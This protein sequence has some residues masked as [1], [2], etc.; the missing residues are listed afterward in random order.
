M[1]AMLKSKIHRVRINQVNLDCAGSVTMDRALLEASDILHY[2]RVEVLNID[3]GAGFGTYAVEGEANCG[4]IGVNDTAAQLAAKGDVVT[5][6]P[7]CQVP[8]DE[9]MG[10]VL[11]VVHHAD[12]QNQIVEIS[13]GAPRWE[14]IGRSIAGAAAFD[15]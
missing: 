11:T 7:Y 13:F 4:I 5:I 14:K 8:D 10:I 2:E 15:C 1:R 12:S 9:A 6:L 3:N